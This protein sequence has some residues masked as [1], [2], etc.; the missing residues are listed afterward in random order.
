MFTERSDEIYTFINLHVCFYSHTHMRESA[1]GT[2]KRGI[3]WNVAKNGMLLG[4]VSTWNHWRLL[5]GR[6]SLKSS[7]LVKGN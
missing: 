2:Q 3:I 1:D 5:V 6:D 7:S 4:Q